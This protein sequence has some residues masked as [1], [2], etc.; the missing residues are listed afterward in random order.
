[1]AHPRRVQLLYEAVSPKLVALQRE[2]LQRAKPF[3]GRGENI[4]MELRVE[5]MTSTS[6]R[7]LNII[8]RTS[9]PA[10]V[11]KQKEELK[12]LYDEMAGKGLKDSSWEAIVS[13]AKI[14]VRQAGHEFR[15]VP[16]SN[17]SSSNKSKDATSLQP[18]SGK[19]GSKVLSGQSEAM[20]P[21]LDRRSTAGKDT[22][23]EDSVPVTDGGPI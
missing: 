15:S 17:A 23:G 13:L 8:Q 16:A 2:V 10:Y 9:A 21:E 20:S 18:T 6:D 1:M 12:K 11:A 3:L 22:T 5:V 7:I 14:T 4:P 19:D